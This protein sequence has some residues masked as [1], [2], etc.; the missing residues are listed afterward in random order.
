MIDISGL[1]H[2]IADTAILADVS[3]TI[4]PK[5]ITALIGPNGAGKSTLL[6]LMCRLMPIQKGRIRIDELEVGHCASDVLA[7]KLA[8]LPQRV[9]VSSR[10]SVSEL[11]SF[12]RYPHSKGRLGKE[13]QVLIDHAIDVFELQTLADRQIDTLSGGQRQRAFLA[14]AF[15]QDTDYL[16]LDE[17]LNNLDIAAV[18]KLM[19]TLSDLS[20]HHDRTIVIVVHDINIAARYADHLIA[21]R[22][23]RCVADGAPGA[24]ITEDFMR[25]TYGTDAEVFERN[26]RPVV[27]V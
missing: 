1:S 27:L 14:M 16:L 8:I 20:H 7:R 19:K 2:S 26:G 10:L 12:G 13:D 9:H 25:Q 3:V 23:G 6:S 17:P 4:P 24:I 18:R 15:A 22:D 11:V 21:L 5:G